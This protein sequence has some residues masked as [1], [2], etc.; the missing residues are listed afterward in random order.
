MT[1]A[2][3]SAPVVTEHDMFSPQEIAAREARY[4]ELLDSLMAQHRCSRGKA[5]RI[6][7]AMQRRV[8]KRF[9]KDHHKRVME[10]QH[11]REMGLPDPRPHAT[12]LPEMLDQVTEDNVHSEISTGEAVGQEAI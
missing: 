3:P 8:L 12:P 5:K 4:E 10:F 2:T 11:C 7:E 9:K 1:N 6:A